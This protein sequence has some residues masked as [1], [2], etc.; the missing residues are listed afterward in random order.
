M[1][2]PSHL[3]DEE[4]AVLVV[5]RLEKAHEA[6]S[7]ADFAISGERWLTA[8]NRIYYAM[9]YATSALALQNNFSTSKHNQL[10]GWFNQQFIATGLLEQRLYKMLIERF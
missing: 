8:V 1:R 2:T 10:H 3:T 6:A 4:R 9:F 7:D 5:I